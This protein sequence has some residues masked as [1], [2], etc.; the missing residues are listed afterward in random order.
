[1]FNNLFSCFYCW[2]KKDEESQKLI[3]DIDFNDYFT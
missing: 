1:M 2:K 3:K